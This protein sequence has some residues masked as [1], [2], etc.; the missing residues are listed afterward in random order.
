MRSAEGIV[1]AAISIICVLLVIQN[2]QLKKQLELTGYSGNIVEPLQPGDDA[3][4]IQCL[5]IDGKQSTITY[6][7]DYEQYLL[8]VFSTK[9]PHCEKSLPNIERIADEVVDSPVDL[10]GVSMHDL[11]E[12][13][14]WVI[15]KRV[16]FR[17]IAVTDSTFEQRYKISGVPT[18]IL[19]NR[20]GVV[21]NV[22]VGEVVGD[23]LDEVLNSL[24]IHRSS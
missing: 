16:N 13:Q 24:S 2:N 18:V 20:K 10:V 21:Q 7:D 11:D 9:C 19:I 3:R 14:K 5:E 1:G 22:W 6:T 15:D 17:V 23:R 12:T 4:P 8:F